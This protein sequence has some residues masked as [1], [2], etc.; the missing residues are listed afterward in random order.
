MR[1]GI[2][3]GAAIAC[4]LA[5]AS[6]SAS[7]ADTTGPIRGTIPLLVDESIHGFDV[8]TSTLVVRP[9]VTSVVTIVPKSAKRPH[10][11]AING[12]GWS[13]VEG[14]SVKPGH[15]TALT[16]PLSPGTYTLYDPYKKNRLRGYAVKIKVLKKQGRSW[17]FGT[18]CPNAY[19]TVTL[20]TWVK[21]TRCGVAEGVA[22]ELYEAWKAND[23]GWSPLT[24]RGFTC[25]FAPFAFSGLTVTCVNGTQTITFAQN[26]T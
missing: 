24:V 20:Q 17:D 7:A 3:F 14:V 4:V 8:P 5:F 6:A 1:R 26:F 15:M 11:I 2:A 22:D 10:G 16:L 19:L 9:G 13:H 21:S 18:N 25:T 23:F 12:R